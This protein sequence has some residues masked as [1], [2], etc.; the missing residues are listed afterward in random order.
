MNSLLK[1]L[2]FLSHDL[3][4]LYVE[5]DDKARVTTGEMLQNLFDNIIVA[6]HGLE[7]LELFAQNSFDIIITDINMPKMNG[8]EMLREIRKQDTKVSVIILSAYNESGY[9]LD[10]IELG[11]DGFIIKPLKFKQFLNVIQKIIYKIQAEKQVEVY[12]QSLEFE[13][14]ERTKELQRKLY[15]DDLT[16]LL[17]RYSFF[18]D[19]HSVDTPILFMIDINKFKIINEIYG[20]SVGSLVLKRF[21]Q[22]LQNFASG[23]TYKVYRLS[24]D[25]FILWDDVDHIDFEKYEDEL[26]RFFQELSTFSVEVNDDT[27]SVEVT[28]GISTAR[29]DA[30]ESAKVALEYAKLHKKPYAMYSTA[31]DKR[32]EEQNALVWKA[33]IKKAIQENNIIPFYQAIVDNHGKIIKYETLMRLRDS[34]TNEYISP[35]YFLDI[36]IKTGL[37]SQLSSYII[38]SALNK[39]EETGVTLSINFTYSDI[40]NSMFI[41]E[42]EEYIRTHSKV[43]HLAVFEITESESIENYDDVKSFI[44]R[45]KK[46]GV[47]FAIDDFGSGFS[48]FEYILEIEPDYLKIDGSLIKHINTDEKSLIL[49]R[50]IVQFSHELGIKV[51]AEYVHSDIVF[52]ILKALNVDEYQGFY[53]A[54]PLPNIEDLDDARL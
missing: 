28:I 48:N 18:E 11:V 10:A 31:I 14:E 47:R 13:V 7:A 51:I 39:I 25:E 41:G 19:I 36:S 9:F 2:R 54:K 34:D 30:F 38:F 23:Q 6:E 24:A 52:N 26:Q 1:E 5:D 40:K 29:E 35:F 50:A 53:F 20:T 27:I 46:Y 49:V 4:L 16:G 43:G 45:F 8:I 15:Y 42:I 3:K 37:Y 44:K 17:S 12:H 21:A 33:K 22:F 32:K